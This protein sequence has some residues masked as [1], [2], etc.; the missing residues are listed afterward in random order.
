MTL[1][2]LNLTVGL[3]LGAVLSGLIVSLWCRRQVAE[4]RQRETEA[5]SQMQA[6]LQW[7]QKTEG[8]LRENLEQLNS[9]KQ[10]LLVEKGELSTE[11]RLQAENL[12]FVEAA[13]ETLTST[14]KALSADTLKENH[15]VFLELAKGSL[16][17][18]YSQS[19]VDL[20]KRSH[21]IETILQPIRETLSRVETQVQTA[22]I[23]R[24]QQTAQLSETLRNLMD[25]EQKLRQET[26]NLSKALRAPQV[27]GRW[28]ELQ[29]KRVVEMA[30]MLEHCD[31]YQQV[32]QAGEERSSRP[33]LLVRLPGGKNIVIDSKA[34]IDSYLEAMQ[35]TDENIKQLKLAE[36]A[37][38]IRSRIADLSK[39]AYWEQFQP[40]PEFVVLFLPGESFFSSALEH[41]PSLLEQ[42]VDQKVIL[43][44]PTTLIALLKAVSYGWRQSRLEENALKVSEL[45]RELSKRL[46]DMLEHFSSLGQSLNRSVDHFNKTVGSLESR[47]LVTARKFDE[48]QGAAAGLL[49]E[50]QPVDKLTR[51]VDFL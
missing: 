43:A 27:R 50:P 40:S 12:Q 32:H 42:S 37:R 6:Q 16:E 35:T 8:E 39:K 21:S 3:I 45:G 18:L 7:L 19:K 44:T 13:R 33:D 17:S 1:D 23:E 2:I 24:T 31:F 47:V 30:G 25:S 36:H 22:Q 10:S 11:L 38:H 29:L 9:D 41:D 34:V 46:K 49:V 14:F 5:V 26:A 20:E 48:L 51:S 28:G 4:S 15:Q